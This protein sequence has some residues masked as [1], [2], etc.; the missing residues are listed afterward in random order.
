VCETRFT[1]EE[2]TPTLHGH[3]VSPGD[4]DASGNGGRPTQR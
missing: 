1:I 3:G 2:G 4:G